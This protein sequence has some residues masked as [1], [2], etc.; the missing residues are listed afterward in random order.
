MRNRSLFFLIILTAVL[1]PSFVFASPLVGFNE[2]I[3]KQLSSGSSGLSAYFFLFLGGILASLL[4]CTYPLYPITI[5][6][7]KARSQNNK[8]FLHPAVYFSGIAAMYFLFGVI[9]SFTGGAFNSVLHFPVTNLL[10]ATVIFLLGLSS[11]DLLH[12]PIFSGTNANGKSKTVVSTFVMGMSAGLLSSACVGPIVVSILIGIASASP[13]FSFTL[14]FTAASK[15][16][17]FGMGVGLPFLLIGV[18]GLKLPKSGKWMKY[19]QMALGSLIVYFSYMY[20]EKALLGFG[21]S[22]SSVYLTVLGILIVLLSVY[23]F[24]PE[25]MIVYQKTK[26]SILFLSFIIGVLVLVK[27]FLP[28]TIGGASTV[29]DKVIAKAPETEQKGALTW[30]LDKEVAYAEAQKKG[31]PVFV[32]FHA[33]WCTNCKEFQKTTQS[34][35]ELNAALKNAILLKVYEGTPT[36]NIY[37]ADT[38]FPELKVGLLFFIITDKDGNLLYKTN[39]YLKADEMSIFLSN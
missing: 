2:W 16:L 6:V 34:N 15:M 3:E 19:I 20:L 38:L 11:A 18:F 9:A 31:K 1:F 22:E 13:T 36:F 27:A 7:L 39:D 4:P 24:Q 32:D 26:R 17:L 35:V 5:N 29:G 8:L 28:L 21:F 30:Y 12:L 37:A 23:H 25:E 33:D 14:A 10:I